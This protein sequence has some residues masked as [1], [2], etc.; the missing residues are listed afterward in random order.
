MEAVTDDNKKLIL[1]VDDDES[2]RELMTVMLS[3]EGYRVETAADGEEGFS[4]ATALAPDLIV[5]DLMLP[6]YGGFELLRQL[7]GGDLARVPII[8]VTGR[9]TDDSTAD[10]IRQ[11]SNVIELLE[12]PVKSTRL[13]AALARVLRSPQPDAAPEA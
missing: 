7:Q 2:I 3:K 5:L 9:Y 11:E 10:M 13:L 4:R 1:V 12:K 8:V 6:R